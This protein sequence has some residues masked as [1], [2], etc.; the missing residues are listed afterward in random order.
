MHL[1]CW[2]AAFAVV[3]VYILHRDEGDAVLLSIGRGTAEVGKEKELQRGERGGAVQQGIKR[4]WSVEIEAFVGGRENDWALNSGPHGCW[5][6]RC[7]TAW[8]TP[9]VHFAPVILEM[10]GLKNYLPGLVSNHGDPPY[11]S[12]SS[13]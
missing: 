12:F 13:S 4:Q 7:S 6:G 5:L 2:G 11:L 3:R 8:A 1:L 10:G 9:P